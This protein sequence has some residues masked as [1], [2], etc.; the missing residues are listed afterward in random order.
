M[1]TKVQIRRNA[2]I[3]SLFAIRKHPAIASGNT[4]DFAPAASNQPTVIYFSPC[5]TYFPKTP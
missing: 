5:W 2:L 3:G 4:G 1:A